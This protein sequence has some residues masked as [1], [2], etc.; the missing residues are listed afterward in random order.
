MRV[1]RNPDGSKLLG[2]LATDV[3]RSYPPEWTELLPVVGFVL[4]VTPGVRGFS[5]WDVGRRWSSA[6][7]LEKELQTFEVEEFAPMAESVERALPG[8]LG[9]RYGVVCSYL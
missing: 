4:C 6:L 7:P 2:L 3:V 1:W 8:D 9:E 5:P